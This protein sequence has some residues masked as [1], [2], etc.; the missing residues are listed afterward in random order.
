MSGLNGIN[1]WQWQWQG[2]GDERRDAKM[3]REED[4][5]LAMMLWKGEGREGW[6]RDV[7]SALP[8]VRSSVTTEC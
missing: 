5:G 7:G 2:S 3:A 4:A 1:G 6:R 8:A